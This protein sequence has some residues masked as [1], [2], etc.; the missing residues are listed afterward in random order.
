MVNRCVCSEVPF[1]AIAELAK[2]GK[3]FEQIRA[4]THCCDGCGT[5]EPY[6]RVVIETGAVDLPVLSAAQQDA[7]MAEARRLDENERSAN[8]PE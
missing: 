6:V 7:I 1:W 3:T 2:Q 5:C 4:A 8:R